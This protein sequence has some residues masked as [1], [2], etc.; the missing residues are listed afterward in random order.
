M[1]FPGYCWFELWTGSVS[2]IMLTGNC[3][4]VEAVILYQECT[5][6]DTSFKHD[7][8]CFIKN[9]DICKSCFMHT[10]AL[11]SAFT[12]F[13]TRLGSSLKLPEQPATQESNKLAA[14]GFFRHSFCAVQ[15]LIWTAIGMTPLNTSAFTMFCCRTCWTEAVRVS[16]KPLLH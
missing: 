10:H 11:L 1:G 7:W 15:P 16:R 14:P 8:I 5:L 4:S 6:A 2:H 13:K 3:I 12:T 9:T